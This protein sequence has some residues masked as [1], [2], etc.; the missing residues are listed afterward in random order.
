MIKMYNQKAATTL[1]EVSNNCIVINLTS[2]VINGN[3]SKGGEVSPRERGN[4]EPSVNT[5]ECID[6]S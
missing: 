4:I 6:L 5:N 1:E 2:E 3:S